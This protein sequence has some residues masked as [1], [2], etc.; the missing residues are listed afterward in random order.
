MAANST[1]WYSY[2]LSNEKQYFRCIKHLQKMIRGSMSYDSW[3]K[4]SKIGIDKCPICS[5][6]RDYVT[7]ESH[8]YPKTL[9]EVVDEY[10]QMLI[11][12][13]TLDDKTDFEVCQEV[14]DL[15]FTR[16]VNYVVLC[17]HCH[18]KY[19]DDVPEVLNIIDEKWRDQKKIIE[20]IKKTNN[21]KKKNNG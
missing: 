19:H 20:E 6:E 18:E 21:L 8:H 11:E 10:L 17:K 7:F 5:I 12:T 15:H 2:D 4:R 9:F 14:M 13:N 16:Q 1:L 3:Q